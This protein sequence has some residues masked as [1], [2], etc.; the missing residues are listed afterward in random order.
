MATL[1]PL[2]QQ[3]RRQAINSFASCLALAPFIFAAAAAADL[4]FRCSTQRLMSSWADLQFQDTTL[5]ENAAWPSALVGSSTTPMM[6]LFND[7]NVPTIEAEMELVTW[8]QANSSGVYRAG[9]VTGL[10]YVFLPA[11]ID[12]FDEGYMVKTPLLQ[13]AAEQASMQDEDSVLM[14]AVRLTVAA[15]YVTQPFVVVS[16]SA[17]DTLTGL[18]YSVSVHG[19]SMPTDVVTQVEWSYMSRS[20]TLPEATT[21]TPPL[22]QRLASRNLSAGQKEQCVVTLPVIFLLGN[23]LL[24][25]W[26]LCTNTTSLAEYACSGQCAS[27]LRKLKCKRFRRSNC[28]YD[29]KLNDHCFFECI[30]WQALKSKPTPQQVMAVRRICATMWTL[31]P[32]QL[33]TVAFKEGM[34]PRAYCSA[35]ENRMWGGALECDLLDQKLGLKIKIVLGNDQFDPLRNCCYLRLHQEHFTLVACSKQ[36]EWR[37][38]ASL[39]KRRPPALERAITNIT[40]SLDGAVDRQPQVNAAPTCRGGANLVCNID[41]PSVNPF[42][43]DSP[44]FL[45]VIREGLWLPEPFADRYPGTVLA[46]PVL[47]VSFTDHCRLTSTIA[48]VIEGVTGVLHCP[49][50]NNADRLAFYRGVRPTQQW[51]TVINYPQETIL[52]FRF[53]LLLLRLVCG[54]NWKIDVF[55]NQQAQSA[56]CWASSASRVVVILDYE[57]EQTYLLYKQSTA[58]R[59]GATF[60]SNLFSDVENPYL[61]SSDY[62]RVLW[63]CEWIRAYCADRLAGI[64]DTLPVF[65]IIMTDDKDVVLTICSIIDSLF[66]RQRCPVIRH[67]SRLQF[68]VSKQ[69]AA[70]D[71]VIISLPSTRGQYG[72]MMQA[73]SNMMNKIS[74]E[75]QI[76]GVRFWGPVTCWARW[77]DRAVIIV[78]PASQYYIFLFKQRSKAIPH[79]LKPA[80]RGGM[81]L[82]GTDSVEFRNAQLQTLRMMLRAPPSLPMNVCALDGSVHHFNTALLDTV[83]WFAAEEDPSPPLSRCPSESWRAYMR[84]VRA[85]LPRAAPCNTCLLDGTE[86]YYNLARLDTVDWFAA[87]EDQPTPLSTCTPTHSVYGDGDIS[88]ALLE[89]RRVFHQF[90]CSLSFAQRSCRTPTTGL[91]VRGGNSWALTEHLRLVEQAEEELMQHYALT[92][93]PEFL[94]HVPH[95]N[96]ADWV[97]GFVDATATTVQLLAAVLTRSLVLGTHPRGIYY[98]ATN[99]LASRSSLS[100]WYVPNDRRA[101]TVMFDILMRAR[102]AQNLAVLHFVFT[103]PPRLHDFVD[104]PPLHAMRF[105]SEWMARVTGAYAVLFDPLEQDYFIIH[106]QS[107]PPAL[108]RG[109]ARGSEEFDADYDNDEAPIEDLSCPKPRDSQPSAEATAAVSAAVDL[110]LEQQSSVTDA[111]VIASEPPS[112]EQ[113]YSGRLHLGMELEDAKVLPRGE[114]QK[115]FTLAWGPLAGQVRSRVGALWN[116]LS[117]FGDTR[118]NL[119]HTSW[120]LEFLPKEEAEVKTLELAAAIRCEGNPDWRASLAAIKRCRYEGAHPKKQGEERQ[121]WDAV[122]KAVSLPTR[123]DYIAR[124]KSATSGQPATTAA[125]S[126]SCPAAAK[127]PPVTRDKAIPPPP[128]KRSRSPSSSTSESSTCADDCR[129]LHLSWSPFTVKDAMEFR[130]KYTR[131]GTPPLGHRR[132]EQHLPQTVTAARHGRSTGAT[133]R[134]LELHHLVTTPAIGRFQLTRTLLRNSLGTVISWASQHPQDVQFTPVARALPVFPKHWPI[135]RRDSP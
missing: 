62:A 97:D 126:S 50:I 135:M 96:H 63:R 26:V 98:F 86:H 73:L 113:E 101:R 11:S 77:A 103:G 104:L 54:C 33:Q 45:Q 92:E 118:S 115:A 80:L 47:T 20:G 123:A 75:I 99:E 24:H 23:R 13:I 36:P 17:L 100:L 93:V 112:M 108:L 81:H 44:P 94:F 85:E 70:S 134:H 124:T 21:H 64:S 88:D 5:E 22:E 48:N 57:E 107:G 31:L 105:S 89:F 90:Q 43:G 35:I 49:V 10:D 46:N 84:V 117:P 109:G 129:P 1:A 52:K 9:N 72:R 69:T 16:A 78:D 12:N 133:S 51:L 67:A 83:D 121:A 6:S 106:R 18:S 8:H 60:T 130:A 14:G 41:T 25:I 34:T 38:F 71:F 29:P 3:C 82:M 119:W 15:D 37:A 120:H 30:A 74:K 61:A 28:V 125:S 110:T 102:H 114:P 131:Q 95:L 59:G 111:A 116:S 40:Q 53:T 56:T 58:L 7:C 127:H 4:C 132:L 19:P 42:L 39:M 2:A 79:L 68:F 128:R 32:S 122:L 65:D 27:R 76:F 55:T 91:P 87:E 66:E